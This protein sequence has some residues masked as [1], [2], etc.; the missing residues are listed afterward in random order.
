MTPSKSKKM[1]QKGTEPKAETRQRPRW[2]T[3]KPKQ[4]IWRDDPFF[5]A[6]LR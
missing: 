6:P 5:M 1:A 2:E 3:I 4:G